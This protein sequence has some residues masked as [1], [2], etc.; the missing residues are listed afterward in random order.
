M[1]VEFWGQEFKVN[2]VVGCIGGFL[3]AIGAL[4]ISLALTAGSPERF[5]TISDQ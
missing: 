4:V 5:S 3:I 1:K 2:M